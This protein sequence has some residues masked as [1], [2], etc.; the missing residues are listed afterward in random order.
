[1]H[2]PKPNQKKVATAVGNLL[3][4][5]GFA[6]RDN[7]NMMDTPNRVAK[8]FINELFSGVYEEPP[9]ITSFPNEHRYS[10]L[11]VSSGIYFHS[12]CSH[13]LLAF[14]G[15]ACIGILPN[16]NGD[17]P[18][19]SKYARVVEHYARRPQ[20]QE[21]LTEEIATHLE[22]ALKPAGI[23]VYLRAK[24]GCACARGIRQATGEMTTIAVRGALRNQDSIKAEF[25]SVANRDNSD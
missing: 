19:Y 1:M 24:H 14:S 16:E 10:Q 21:N 11:V 22:K 4:S 9:I 6:W 2:L 17:L 8:M 23:G 3:T 12:M 13:H 7:P 5:L 18:G 20:L 25:L 15:Y